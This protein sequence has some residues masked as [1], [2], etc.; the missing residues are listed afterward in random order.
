MEEGRPSATA[1]VAAMMRAAHVLLDDEPKILRD[2]LAL[3]LSGVEHEAALRGALEGLQAEITQGTTP[4]FAHSLLR[5]LRALTTWRSRYVEDTLET[6]IQRGVAQYVILGAGLDSF[7]YRRRDVANVLRVFEVDHPATQQW[8]WARLHALGVEIPPNVTFMPID[9][10]KQT[11]RE[12]LRAGGYRLEEPGVFSWLGVTGYLTEDAI[13]STLRDVIALAPGSEIVFEYVI[14]DS[15]LDA[16]SQRMAAVLKAGA[17][18]RGEPLRSAF[19]PA[20]LMAQLRGLGF[21][22][23][24]ELGPEGANARYFTG[25]TDGLRLLVPSAWYLMRARLGG[26]H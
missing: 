1:I 9:F 10:E 25:R 26:V 7:A 22:E 21:A 19:D 18:A 3:R 14:L 17:A 8:K 4:A 11:L 13:L 12:G 23:V 15:L 16:D 2:D 20:S 6:A 5:Y 24:W